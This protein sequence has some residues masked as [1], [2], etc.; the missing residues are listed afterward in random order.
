M[1]DEDG[2]PAKAPEGKADGGDKASSAT[3]ALMQMS[4]VKKLT[5]P[6]AWFF[7]L[8]EPLRKL[9]VNIGILAAII[10][11]APAIYKAATK[12]NFIIR[13]IAVPSALADRGFT[14]DVIAQQILDH[15][16]E[17]DA[18]AGS[19]KEKAEIS[20]FDL[21]STMPDITLP[22]GG[23]SIGAVVA[24]VRQLLGVKET[25]ITG[26]IVIE[27]PGNDDKGA[28]PQ[29]GLRLRI[30]GEG[31]IYR[32]SAPDADIGKLVDAAAKQV[33]RK[34]DPINL[35]YFYFRQRDY[36]SAYDMT[37]V[38]LAD[39]S[40]DNDP[41]AFTMRGLIARERGHLEDAAL[42]VREAIKRSPTFWLGYVNLADLL[43]LSN[44]LDEAEAAARKAIELAP[45][46]QEGYAT[47]ALIH[48]DRGKKDDALKEMQKGVDLDRSDPKGHLQLGRLLAR[49]EKFEA[50]I[51]S[52]RASA[53]LNPTAEPFVHSAD[54]SRSLNRHA[55]VLAFLKQATSAE[56]QNPQAWIALGE[57]ELDRNETGPGRTALEKAIAVDPKSA[58]TLV[59]VANAWQTRKRTAD[60]AALYTK[61]FKAFAGNPDFLLGWSDLLWAE[62][63]KAEATAR[64]QEALANAGESAAI[65]EQ[66]G[67]MFEARAEIPEAIDAYQKAIGFDPTLEPVLK[68]LIEKVALRLPVRPV[69]A[70][71][72][73]P[74]P[75]AP[76][77]RR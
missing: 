8:F 47:L 27:V 28:P 1:S 63:K 65:F 44:R 69:P 16:A 46:E 12:P 62:G 32:S 6:F 38:A 24:E 68:P 13:D 14:S 26:E 76:A 20:G 30:A 50:A 70:A 25:K 10:F 61:N 31:P 15:I 11:G 43:R 72:P 51:E 58:V 55:D 66:A 23:I 53:V 3:D 59:R 52:C 77:A 22:V 5:A 67:R 7:G 19:K 49:M 18:T 64:L 33:M 41:W 34:Y 42:Q 40:P 45:K 60:A 54:A 56:P 73:A 2:T 71:V 57:A 29:Y 37:E 9:V 35:G 39:P 48:M 74:L 17:V 36:R 75:P 21:Q 4:F